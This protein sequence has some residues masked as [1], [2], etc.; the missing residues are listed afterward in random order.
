MIAFSKSLKVDH[1]AAEERALKNLADMR[2]QLSLNQESIRFEDFGASRSDDSDPKPILKSKEISQIYKRASIPQTWSEFLFRLVRFLKPEKILEI[3]TN[4]GVGATY[5]QTALDLNGTGKLFS[6][7]GS[8]SLSK[9]AETQLDTYCDGDADLIIGPFSK[10]LPELLRKEN[11]FSLVFIDG[12][13]TE[14]A[15]LHYFELI[16]P[17]LSS[18][19]L[20]V[21]DD[22]EP[23]SPVKKAW[24]KILAEEK[25]KASKMDAIYLFKKGLVY[26]T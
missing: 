12:H 24:S 5:L 6:L 15:T 23:W 17:F 21:F 18:G 11:F 4:I 3:G 16:R 10:T 1:S 20:L 25:A 8:G 2:R 13:H 9:F 26:F 22:L 19:S 7:E 14:E